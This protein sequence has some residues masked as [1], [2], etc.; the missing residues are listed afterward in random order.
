MAESWIAGKLAGFFSG[1]LPQLLKFHVSVLQ[2][3]GYL[4]GSREHVRGLMVA[5]IDTIL[6]VLPN[7]A[8]H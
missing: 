7:I 3:L 8:S 1:H 6:G 5:A 4:S 2:F